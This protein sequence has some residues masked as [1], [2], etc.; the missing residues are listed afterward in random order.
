MTMKICI[1]PKSIKKKTANFMRSVL[2]FLFIFDVHFAGLGLPT[3]L[4]TRRIVIAVGL[5]WVWLSGR[6][7]RPFTG[8]S[9]L[10]AFRGIF[11]LQVL[12]LIHAG[13]LLIVIGRGE[14]LHIYNDIVLF[15][16]TGLLAARVF[17][18]L[19]NSLEDFLNGLISVTLIQ[20]AIIILF[21]AI[22]PLQQT[23]DAFLGVAELNENLRMRGYVTGFSCSTSK[24]TLKLTPAIAACVYFIIEEKKR[25]L[26]YIIYFCIIGAFAIIQAR[27]GLVVVI[28]GVSAMLFGTGKIGMKSLFRVLR[29]LAVIILLTVSIIYIFQLSDVLK[30]LLWRLVDLFEKGLYDGFFKAYFGKTVGSTTVVPPVNWKTIIGTGIVSG[31][32]GNGIAVNV[33]GGFLRLYTALGLPWSV[34]FYIVMLMFM[35]KPF[36][37]ASGMAVK[38]LLFFMVIYIFVIGETKEFFIYDGYSIALYFAMAF[39]HDKDKYE[40]KGGHFNV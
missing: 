10:K 5:M 7:Q 25:I 16:L 40:L 39:L 4:T 18:C 24:G 12:L 11:V 22:S 2:L 34:L 32:S 21:A 23:V 29:P 27:T 9:S 8:S 13:V 30:D 19:Y 15:F 33:D 38:I 14:G 28:F 26:K 31:E 35:L 36:R 37:H 20:V 1:R 17:A 6:W 3:F